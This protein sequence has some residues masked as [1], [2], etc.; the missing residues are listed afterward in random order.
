MLKGF[1]MNTVSCQDTQFSLL[2]SAQPQLRHV[3]RLCFIAALVSLTAA[4]GLFSPGVKVQKDA[5]G[6]STPESLYNLAKEELDAKGF[7]KSIELYE[8]VSAADAL[9]VYGQQALLDTAYAQ[10]KNE[11]SV[12]SLTSLE[13]YTRQ[14][15]KAAGVPYAMYLKGLIKFNDRSGLLSA[16]SKEDLS[17]RDPKLLRESYEAFNQLIK[18][19]PNTTYAKDAGDRLT[20]LVNAM[21]QHEI[22]VARYYLQRG[23]PLAAVNRAQD[24]LKQYSEVP[25]QEEA[26]GIMVKSYALLN[27]PELQGKSLQVLKTNYPNSKYLADNAF[28]PK[29]KSFFA[30]W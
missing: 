3:A 25:A 27:L 19:H 20:F 2:A 9:G 7:A 10:W 17:E 26:L 6:K 16:F 29:R 12:A 4:C 22:N 15:P 23:A 11:D 24:M 5:F 21:A 1:S 30:L 14:F 13:R 18:Q 28:A 8:A